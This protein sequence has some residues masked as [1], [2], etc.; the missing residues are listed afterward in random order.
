METGVIKSLR[1]IVDIKHLIRKKRPDM[2]I[3]VDWGVKHQFK[4]IY[5]NKC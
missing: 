3:A 2:A 5:Q 1:R 4:Q